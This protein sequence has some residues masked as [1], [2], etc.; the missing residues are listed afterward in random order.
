MKKV[1]I[2]TVVTILC[3]ALL[4]E[5]VSVINRAKECNNPKN[6]KAVLVNCRKNAKFISYKFNNPET[7]QLFE[8]S[9][10]TPVVLMTKE[11]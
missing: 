10:F 8:L 2:V 6:A 5:F 4:V 11:T 7:K 9:F 3:A 1:V